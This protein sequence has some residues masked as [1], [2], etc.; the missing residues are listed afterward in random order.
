MRA[1]GRWP[2][3]IAF[4]GEQDAYVNNEAELLA[5]FNLQGARVTLSSRHG[6]AVLVISLTNT[7]LYG[8]ETDDISPRKC[9]PGLNQAELLL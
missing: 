2:N 7:R 3:R 1:S 5:W 6:R 9:Y 8:H 4:D